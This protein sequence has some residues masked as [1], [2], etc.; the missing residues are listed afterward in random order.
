MD[1]LIAFVTI[2]VVISGAAERLV[3][4][5][6]TL[7][8]FGIQAT[9]AQPKTNP[10]AESTRQ[11]ILHCIALVACLG[12]TY[13]AKDG[14]A[15]AL[16]FDK[17]KDTLVVALALLSAGGSSLWNSVLTYLLSVKDI[18]KADATERKLEVNSGAAL[19]SGSVPATPPTTLGSRTF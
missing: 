17:N 4:I 15:A 1:Q 2:L 3:E 9:L 14:I 12:T 5:I 19:P 6:K 7:P 13:L 16:H 8:F 11:F 10:R 18:K